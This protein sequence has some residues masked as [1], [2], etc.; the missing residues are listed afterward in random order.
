MADRG[1]QA[2]AGVLLVEDDPGDVLMTGEAFGQYRT[3]IPC[4]WS[5]T[6]SSRCNFCAANPRPSRR[7]SAV[8]APD[9]GH[10]GCGSR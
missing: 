5:A 1:G 3:A 10:S 4:R 6:A 9:P 2:L 8:T 7:Q